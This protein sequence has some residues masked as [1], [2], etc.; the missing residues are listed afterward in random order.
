LAF[1]DNN[2]RLH[3]YEID[4]LI[5]LSV[6]EAAE[7]YRRQAVFV[8][9]IYTARP[10]REQLISL[11]LRVA[12]TRSVFFQHADVFPKHLAVAPPD[13]ILADTEEILAGLSLWSDDASRSEYVAQIAWHLIARDSMPDW[14]PSRQT[15]FPEGLFA[16]GE[17]GVFVDCGAFDGDSVRQF[18]ALTKGRFDRILAVEADPSNFEVLGTYIASLPPADRQRIR[19]EQVAVYSSRQTLRFAAASGVGSSISQGGEITVNA[20]RLD[21]LLRGLNPTL[22]KMDIEGAEPHALRGAVDTLKT[23]GPS[24]AVCLYHERDHLWKIPTFIRSTNP[25]YRLFLRRHSDEIWETL[26]Y[27]HTN[28][29]DA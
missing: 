3:G 28:E 13:S 8:T 19:A 4:G 26:C 22:I 23:A 1:A 15:Y 24:L 20:E 12:S 25:D 17:H 18:I 27:A 29:R 14:T 6:T 7:E 5:V 16:L 21:D 9:T 2:P 10:L 11:G